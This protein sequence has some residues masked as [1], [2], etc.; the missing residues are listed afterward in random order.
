MHYML[1]SMWAILRYTGV[2]SHRWIP[3]V[4]MV[5]CLV[6]QVDGAVLLLVTIAMCSIATYTVAL[7][8]TRGSTLR[9][10]YLVACPLLHSA[11]HCWELH[12]LS[13]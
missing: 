11:L 5:M 9:M 2:P 6:T 3:V 13:M 8:A 4:L 10:Y 1:L 12:T 7:S